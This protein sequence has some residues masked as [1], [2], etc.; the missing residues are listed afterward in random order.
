MKLFFDKHADE[1][2]KSILSIDKSAP[3]G[4]EEFN[5]TK[6]IWDNCCATLVEIGETPS[7]PPRETDQ[8]ISQQLLMGHLRRYK[9]QCPNLV[10]NLFTKLPCSHVRI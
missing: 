2:G 6:R 5:R 7:P 4:V 10:E 9:H 1:L 3:Q 8:K